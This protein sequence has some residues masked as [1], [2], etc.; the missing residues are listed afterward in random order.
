MR[1]NRTRQDRKVH[2][3]LG[4]GYKMYWSGLHRPV[5]LNASKDKVGTDL[6]DRGSVEGEGDGEDLER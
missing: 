6:E 1:W 2:E 3:W 4:M 5:A